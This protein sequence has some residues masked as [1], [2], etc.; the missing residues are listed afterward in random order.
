LK[1]VEEF[2]IEQYK[3]GRRDL[4]IRDGMGSGAFLG[5]DAFTFGLWQSVQ[6]INGQKSIDKVKTS[7]REFKMHL[8]H[9]MRNLLKALPPEFLNISKLD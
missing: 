9:G 4:Q 7:L 6:V 3:E 8:Y 1:T 2:E 5:S